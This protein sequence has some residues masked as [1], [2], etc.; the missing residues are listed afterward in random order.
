MVPVVEDFMMK[1][2]PSEHTEKGCDWVVF[3]NPEVKKSLD[4]NLVHTLLHER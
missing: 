4:I 1:P 3:Y 2:V